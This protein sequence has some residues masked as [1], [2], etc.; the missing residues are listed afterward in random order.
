M[1]RTIIDGEERPV[2]PGDVV[3]MPAGV[4]HTLIADSRIQAVEVQIGDEIDV[5]DK[6]KF[7]L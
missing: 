7:E 1:G 3:T 6:T 5:A 4:K 2:R